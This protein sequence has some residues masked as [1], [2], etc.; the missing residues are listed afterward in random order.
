VV[1]V[2]WAAEANNC[3]IATGSDSKWI[4]SVDIDDVLLLPQV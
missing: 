3:F 4:T 1:V 2:W